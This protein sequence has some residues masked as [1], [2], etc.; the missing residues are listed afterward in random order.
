MLLVY[1]LL[2][3]HVMKFPSFKFQKDVY[4]NDVWFVPCVDVTKCLSDTNANPNPIQVVINEVRGLQGRH[5]DT[6][7][8]LHKGARI[9]Q[10]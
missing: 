9:I 3:E 7:W 8:P 4:Y 2:N 5:Y 10:L 1:G 6:F